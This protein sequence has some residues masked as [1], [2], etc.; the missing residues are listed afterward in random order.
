MRSY[1]EISKSVR[2]CEGSPAPPPVSAPE[3]IWCCYKANSYKSKL[4]INYKVKWSLHTTQMLCSHVHWTIQ[5]NNLSH[6][7]VRNQLNKK[8]KQYKLRWSV[9]VIS[10]NPAFI[11]WH[12]RC[13]TVSF[14]RWLAKQKWGNVW[15]A[16]KSVEFPLLSCYNLNP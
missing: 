2:G 10:N 7:I 5:S 16:F 11:E 8:F 3:C 6:C 14:N 9:D 13:T 12:V 15:F 4:Q 1:S